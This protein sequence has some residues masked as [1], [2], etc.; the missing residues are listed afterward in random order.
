M[1]KADTSYFQQNTTNFTL[2]LD[3]GP[4]K[5]SLV[6]TYFFPK[7]KHILIL[8]L[9]NKRKIIIIFT[10]DKVSHRKTLTGGV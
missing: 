3:I 2:V 10:K 8:Y 7:P 5:F 6:V 9:S 4:S 1:T